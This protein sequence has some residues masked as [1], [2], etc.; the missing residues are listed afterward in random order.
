MIY[1]KKIQ[2]GRFLFSFEIAKELWHITTDKG[3]VYQF[4]AVTKFKLPKFNNQTGYNLVIGSIMIRFARINDEN[5][6]S[7]T[8]PDGE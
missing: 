1:E 5:Y 2:I 6:F 4:F 7:N 8:L 3:I